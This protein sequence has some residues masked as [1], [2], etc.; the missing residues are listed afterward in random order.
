LTIPL[1]KIDEV[2]DDIQEE[3][4]VEIF[5]EVDEKEKL[6]LDAIYVDFSKYLCGG[7]AHAMSQ[8]KLEDEFFSSG[9]V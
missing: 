9:G 8:R 6:C 5:V 7:A 3:I 4:I 1:K 2:E